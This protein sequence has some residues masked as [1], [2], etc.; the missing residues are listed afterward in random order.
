[1]IEIEDLTG[2]PESKRRQA[3]ECLDD[4]LTF[5]DSQGELSPV[6]SGY[7][8]YLT[9]SASD[10]VI[11]FSNIHGTEDYKKDMITDLEKLGYPPQ[12]I[13]NCIRKKAGT[14]LH[15]LKFVIRDNKGN[16]LP[17]LR[18][19]DLRIGDYL[20]LNKYSKPLINYPEFK[21]AEG[22]LIDEDQGWELDMPF[23]NKKEL[24]S[25]VNLF[26]NK[27]GKYIYDNGGRIIEEIEEQL[28]KRSPWADVYDTP[29]LLLGKSALNYADELPH[30]IPAIKMALKE[31][32]NE[33]SFVIHKNLEQLRNLCHYKQLLRLRFNEEE[34]L[35]NKSF[36]SEYVDKKR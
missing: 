10:S 12:T 26:L 13:L 21:D 31:N 16:L 1:M 32:S 15:E 35:G 19:K 17:G 34:C 24:M 8:W 7:N 3:I 30:F 28:Q 2:I 22:C 11:T 23:Y 14:F 18:V 9:L 20:D 5:R 33:I 36:I 4:L 25:L 29:V 27:S 6:I